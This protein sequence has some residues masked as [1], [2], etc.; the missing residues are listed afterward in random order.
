[1]NRANKTIAIWLLIGAIGFFL[2]PWYA[3]QDSILSTT[4]LRYIVS[5]DNAPALVQGLRFGR[6][7]LL[8]AGIILLEGFELL[9]P[10]S[11]RRKQREARKKNDARNQQPR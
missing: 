8:V 1:M 3:L 10:A 9:A 6:P 7:W 2:L 4:W 5:K 11:G